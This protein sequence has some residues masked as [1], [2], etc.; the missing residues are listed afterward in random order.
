MAM[1]SDPEARDDGI[2]SGMEIDPVPGVELEA[3]I[4]RLYKTPPEVIALVKKIVEAR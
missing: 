2:K 1:L 3:L 4:N